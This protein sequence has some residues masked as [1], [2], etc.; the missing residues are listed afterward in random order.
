MLKFKHSLLISV[1][2]HAC[3]F[4]NY[5][6]ELELPETQG[7]PPKINIK[8]E[9]RESSMPPREVEVIPKKEDKYILS[10]ELKKLL[11]NQGLTDNT[12]VEDDCEKHNYIGIGILHDWFDNTVE[13]VYKG[14]PAERAGIIIGDVVVGHQDEDG[15][16]FPGTKNMLLPKIGSVVL[17]HIRRMGIIIIIP[18]K[19]EKI[20]Q[21]G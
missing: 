18:I 15:N 7:E 3:L 13:K 16:Y 21:R 4:L 6:Q 19:R 9:Q 10:N 11:E 17:V 1:L 20:C 2:L 12:P 5:E 8:L 14:Y